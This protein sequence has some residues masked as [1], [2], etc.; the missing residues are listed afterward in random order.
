MKTRRRFIVDIV[1]KWKKDYPEEYKEWLKLIK[2]K[3]EQLKDKKFAEAEG[4]GEMR[5]AASIPDKIHNQLSY[6]LNGVDE[7]PFLQEEGEMKW[8]VK[9]YPEFLL[10]KS[11]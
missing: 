9:K 3:R 1:E 4:V 5:K 11:Y 6:V 10:S 7:K 8:F 2:W